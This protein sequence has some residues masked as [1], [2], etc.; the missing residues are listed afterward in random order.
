MGRWGEYLFEV[1]HDL[2]EASSISEDAGIELYYYELESKDEK[3]K[4]GGKGIEA[5]RERLNNGILSDLFKRYSEFKSGPEFWGN[6]D[7]KLVSL[8]KLFYYLLFLI[9]DPSFRINHNPTSILGA[10]AMRVGA[11][12]SPEHMTLLRN[13]YPTIKVSPKYSSPL[14]DFN[15]RASMKK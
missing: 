12:I 14:C 10:L 4:F 8:G 6:P 2:D 3:H 9:L 11:Y 13:R 1:D 7:V 15:F 5:T